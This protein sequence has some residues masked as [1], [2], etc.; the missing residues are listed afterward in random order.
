MQ[1]QTQSSLAIWTAFN[2]VTTA[3]ARQ[4]AWTLRIAWTRNSSV[5]NYA[6]IGSS[7]IDGLDIVQGTV[8]SITS[9]D[10]Y[11]YFEE[12]ERLIRFEFDRS[13]IEPQ[14]GITKCVADFI[15]EN[16][17]GRFTP[18]QNGTIGTSILPNR[19]LQMYFGF[20]V[21]STQKTV[22]LFKGL[23]RQPRLNNSDKT[24][25]IQAI[26]IITFLDELKLAAT[27]YEDQR[28]D[29]LIEAIL[30]EAGLDSS[31][32]V[33]DTGLNT[34]GFSYFDSTTSAGER[35]R[36][37]VEA[38]EGIFFQDEDGVL[39]FETRTHVQTAP[40]NISVWDLDPDDITLWEEEEATRI[41]N[42]AII[43]GSS[44]VISTTQ[45]VA[46][47]SVELQIAANSSRTIWLDYDDPVSSITTPVA[48][49]DFTA[50]S[51]TEGG[52]SNVTT[53]VSI[54]ATNFVNKVKLVIT[55]STAAIAYVNFL[56]VRGTP[57]LVQ[58]SFEE[59][60]EDTDSIAKFE[61]RVIEIDNDFI[62]DA[63]HAQSIARLLVFK[64]ALPKKQIKLT[65]Q[66]VPQIQLKDR[67][68]VK[69]PRLLTYSE[70]RVMR[71]QGQLGQ[72]LFSQILY[73]REITP[74]EDLNEGLVGS[75]L[76][77]SSYVGI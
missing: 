15:L 45:I 3:Y 52:G 54:T 55:N 7:V 76:V 68:R 16:T 50:F 67:V 13:I 69:D 29:E 17:D 41:I 1:G 60:Y 73:L 42:K 74:D 64:F 43:R 18:N 51:A 33:L 40:Q 23:T 14:S 21:N 61:E 39:H 58:N 35:I 36:K 57:A 12:T 49:T 10:S 72:G 63:D 75:A 65:V 77:G 47:S 70:W 19:P 28:S 34:I 44:R 31:Q 24:V 8:T 48:T 22:P 62:D 66:G 37:I 25:S 46:S 56:Q 2:N 4:L 20:I 11:H 38:E 27:T 30:I 6:S 71:I 32:Y 5:T 59:E 9:L 26:D 53:S